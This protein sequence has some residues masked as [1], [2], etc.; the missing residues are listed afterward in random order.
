MGVR[1]FFS[2]LYY[3]V[4]SIWKFYCGPGWDSEDY[5]FLV[6]VFTFSPYNIKKFE[7]CFVFNA[8]ITNL[9]TLQ[10]FKRKGEDKSS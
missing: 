7:K 6:S 3:V 1:I 4:Y 10:E 2:L 8:W 5:Y 9:M